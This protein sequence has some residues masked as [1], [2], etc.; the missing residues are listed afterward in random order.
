MVAG[1][2]IDHGQVLCVKKGATRFNYTA[3]K[4]EFP[5]GK[6]EPGES[7]EAALKRELLE[8]MNM[9]VEVGERLTTITHEYPD[10]TITMQAYLCHLR[11]PHFAL[12]EHEQ[13]AWLPSSELPTLEWCAA[14]VPIALAAS[15]ARIH[16]KQ[17]SKHAHLKN[18]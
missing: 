5:G 3:H 18:Y 13:Y 17:Q 11:S 15:K 16:D 12:T 14:D 1:V 2:V 4:W 6:I 10:F 9:K 7:P 8:E